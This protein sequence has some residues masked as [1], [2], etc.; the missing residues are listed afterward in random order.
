MADSP[1]VAQKAPAEHDAHPVAPVL[2]WSWPEGQEVQVIPPPVENLPE[3]QGVNPESPV[4]AQR[5]PAGH[6][7]HEVAAETDRYLPEA[8]EVQPPAPAA[9]YLPD[10]HAV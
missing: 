3:A 1:A 4:V 9:E 10:E 6:V 7:M 8:H 2:G 5:A